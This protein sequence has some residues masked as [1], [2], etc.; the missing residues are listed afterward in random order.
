MSLEI[1]KMYFSFK[2]FLWK[3]CTRTYINFPWTIM[4]LQW[5]DNDSVNQG[6]IAFA[7]RMCT[8]NRTHC[9]ISV[10]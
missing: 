6:F 7:K 1:S 9:P 8:I 4:Q 10:N 3:I 5:V 2:G